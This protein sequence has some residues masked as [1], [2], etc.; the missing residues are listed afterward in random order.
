M[1]NFDRPHAA[2]GDQPP[3]TVYAPSPRELPARLPPL[4]YPGHLEV[5]RVSSTG[6]IAWRGRPLFLTE[7]LAGEDVALEEVDDGIWTLRFGT[8]H[9]A[10]LDERTRVLSAL[11]A[12]AVSS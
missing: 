12:T 7:V 8:I 9:L 5:R 2:L 11:L 4:Q 6:S 3:V 10:R 1:Y